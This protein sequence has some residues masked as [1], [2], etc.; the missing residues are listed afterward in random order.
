[1]L[2][3]VSPIV[4]LGLMKV[5]VG[6]HREKPVGILIGLLVAILIIAFAL[7]ER[8]SLASMAGQKLIADHNIEHSRALRAPRAEE[9]IDAFAV[10]GASALAGTGFEIYGRML[11]AADSG[12]CG[13]G[14]GGGGGGCGGCGGS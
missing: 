5:V 14:G 4:L 10:T 8:R 2:L 3:A 7:G 6:A 1:M 13:G 9:V 11:T 12:G